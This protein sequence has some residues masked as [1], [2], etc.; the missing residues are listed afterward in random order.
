M[1]V[2]NIITNTMTNKINTLNSILEQLIQRKIE[3]QMNRVMLVKLSTE[4]C[5]LLKNETDSFMIYSGF[6]AISSY[7]RYCNPI[8][9]LHLITFA[10]GIDFD[11]PVEEFYV[12]PMISRRYL[13][14]KFK[15]NN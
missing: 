5:S 13:G 6:F 4:I 2:N 10:E 8:N 3:L 11:L 1:K 9:D 14:K 15:V 7:S 12:L